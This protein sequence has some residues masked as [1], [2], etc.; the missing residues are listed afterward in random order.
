MDS[1]YDE[2]GELRRRVAILEAALPPD[3]RRELAIQRGIK[4]P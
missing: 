4:L 2:I 3:I 1:G